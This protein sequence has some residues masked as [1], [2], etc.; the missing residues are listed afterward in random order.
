MVSFAGK[1]LSVPQ[2]TKSSLEQMSNERLLHLQEAIK[3]TVTQRIANDKPL[4]LEQHKYVSTVL[5]PGPISER[6]AQAFMDLVN[7]RE[8]AEVQKGF[9]DAMAEVKSQYVPSSSSLLEPSRF[10]GR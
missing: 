5:E 3:S 4:T 9:Y 8:S 6:K 2:G 10:T 7:S 1:P